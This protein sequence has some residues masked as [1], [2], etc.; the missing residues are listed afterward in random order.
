M[1][2]VKHAP[3]PQESPEAQEPASLSDIASEAKQSAGVFETPAIEEPE[4][5]EAAPVE[6]VNEATIDTQKVVVESIS[7]DT[8]NA[9]VSSTSAASDD[10]PSAANPAA[11][12]ATNG[13]AHLDQV[14]S[15]AE[16]PGWMASVS[17]MFPPMESSLEAA[18]KAELETLSREHGA[19]PEAILGARPDPS[20]H[21]EQVKQ[22]EPAAHA[23]PE[24]ASE[25]TELSEPNLLTTAWPPPFEPKVADAELFER[26]TLPSRIFEI[27]LEAAQTVR[28]PA[29]QLSE[30][31]SEPA[32]VAAAPVSL[33]AAPQ[34]GNG[35]LQTPEMLEAIVTRIVERMQPQVIDV[36]TREILRPLVEALV[37]REI[38]KH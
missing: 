24:A 12:A 20:S 35:A 10:K 28:A 21:T 22:E 15:L 37:R 33:A 7:A 32:P 3:A 23:A 8:L 19:I 2:T 30:P 38:D 5:V 29:P 36:V 27:P 6:P 26:P 31:V 9:E 25:S 11:N 4:P 34:T 14:P 17:S 13:D 16:M 1:S 18:A